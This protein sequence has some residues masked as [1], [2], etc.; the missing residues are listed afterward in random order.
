MASIDASQYDTARLIEE[1]RPFRL[2]HYAELRSTNDLAVEMRK[3]G[4]L[5]APAIILAD[6]QTAGRGRG[7]NRWHSG[8]GAITITYVV[9][10][11]PALKAHQLPLVAGL[12][13]R[14][15]A[16]ELTSNPDIA[17]KWPN[18]IL[19]AGRKIAGLLCERV[20]GADLIGI[21]MNVNNSDMPG[22]LKRSAISLAR[23]AGRPLDLTSAAILLTQHLRNHL[24]ARQS[25]PF[26]SF[27][28]E[29]REHDA[30]LGKTITVCSAGDGRTIKGSCEGI[31]SEGRLL[32]RGEGKVHR[33]VAGTVRVQ[34]NRE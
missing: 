30:L 7:A 20:S 27:L 33:I 16:A 25:R 1:M 23:I 21:G 4:E 26:A 5:F 28:A 14:N 34:A 10:A 9:P 2:H 32:L 24:M 17:V 31:D 6:S 12:A 11:D 13:V 29:Y 22:E 15:A 18:D 3:R 8:A 19:H